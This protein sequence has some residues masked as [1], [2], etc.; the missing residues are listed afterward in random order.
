MKNSKNCDHE[1]LFLTKKKIH[2]FYEFR[3]RKIMNFLEKVAKEKG[4]NF[5]QKT[6]HPDETEL[7]FSIAGN[8]YIQEMKFVARHRQN[9]K[10]FSVKKKGYISENQAEI[11]FE[12]KNLEI[13]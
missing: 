4:Y 11:L 10:G 2:G 3:M 5:Y 9:L 6:F 7:Q 12:K 13:I 8:D 1:R